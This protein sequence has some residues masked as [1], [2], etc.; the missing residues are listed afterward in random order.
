MISTHVKGEI[1]DHQLFDFC[2]R[3]T[4]VNRFTINRRSNSSHLKQRIE[5]KLQCNNVGQIIYK[6]P[7]WFAENQVKFYQKKIQDDDD[8]QHMFVCHEQS[9]YNDI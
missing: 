1:F 7:I 4:E 3:N 6:N 5:K 9:G 8:V 2:F